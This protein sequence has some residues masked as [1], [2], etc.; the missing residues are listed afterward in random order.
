VILTESSDSTSAG[1]AGDSAVMVD[2]LLTGGP[3]L[4]AL[5]TVV[6]P[7]AVA[8]CTAAGVGAGVALTVGASIDPR[9]GSPVAISGA[10]TH[11]DDGHFRLSGPV[12]TGLPV[13][14]GRRAV[15]T[16]GRL[17]VL[18]TEGSA[19]SYDPAAYR[20]AGLEPAAADVVVVRSACAFRAGYAPLSSETHVLDTAGAST[21]RFTSLTYRAAPR[22]LYPLERP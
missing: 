17:N 20:S 16:C 5:V 11:L 4:H 3:D 15:L 13:S 7:R 18:L 10:V 22:P 21:P 8:H 12:S 1:A 14:S 19:Y 6:D 2:A 9:F